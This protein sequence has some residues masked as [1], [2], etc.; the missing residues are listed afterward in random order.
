MCLLLYPLD[1]PSVAMALF[2]KPPIQ[3]VRLWFSLPTSRGPLV[4]FLGANDVYRQMAGEGRI[5]V[6]NALLLSLATLASTFQCCG[7]LLS[8]QCLHQ[9][10][11]IVTRADPGWTGCPFWYTGHPVSAGNLTYHVNVGLKIEIRVYI[12]RRPRPVTRHLY[13]NSSVGK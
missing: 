2:L 7:L 13:I 10:H 3:L 9:R 11:Y 12:N 4:T 5:L 1:C 8:L 6:V